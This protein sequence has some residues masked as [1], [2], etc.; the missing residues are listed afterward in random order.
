MATAT[1]VSG[2]GTT[3]TTVPHQRTALAVETAT[4][5]ATAGDT[6]TEAEGRRRRSLLRDRG[7]LTKIALAVGVTALAAVVSGGLAVAS[8]RGIAT[9][10]E[11]VAEIQSGL[12]ADIAIVHQEELK[13]RMLIAQVMAAATP[14]QREEWA[15]QIPETDAALD[16]AAA[17]IDPLLGGAGVGWESF[18]ENWAEWKSVRDTMLLPAAMDDDP[19]TFETKRRTIAQ[20]LVDKFVADL[21]KVEAGLTD[22]V[23]GVSEA[24][25]AEAAAA[26]MQYLLVLGVGLAIAA[27]VS[28]VVAHTIRRDLVDAQRSVAAMAAGDLTVEAPVRG[29][30]EVGRMS[31][32]LAVAQ[33]SL[34]RTLSEVDRT[35]DH[36]ASAAEELSA[37]GAQ[38]AAGAEETS[39][40][41]GV[42]AAA[43]EQ[44][45]RNVQAVAAGAEQMGASIRE[46]AQNAH[47]AARVAERATGVAAATNDQV[48]KLGV[49]S[50]EIGDVVK[51]ITSIAEQTNLLALNATI[52]AARAGEAGKGFAVVAGEVKELAQETARA[53][54]DI[55]RR[56]E[57]IQADTDGAVAAI[58]EISAIIAQINDFQMTIA[59]AVEEQTA[60]TNE[61]SRSVTEAAT[62]A[63]EIA[64]NITGVAGAAQTSSG[65]ATQMQSAVAELAR[66]AAELRGLIKV[67]AV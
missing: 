12:A 18:L 17:R 14:G 21:E 60:T 45:S 29:R 3:T 64:A 11:S 35:S 24:A 57:A 5:G 2:R 22:Y 38:V 37:A 54:E 36:V 34:R 47:E 48:A 28:Y 46:I 32:E 6:A 56:V 15:A 41:A 23:T 19:V 30:D 7:V 31:A 52:E 61:I 63:G 53:T 59:S 1:K 67:F 4:T 8:M 25:Q 39:A 62:G 65:V 20:P 44:V 51:V 40:Q 43:A 26:Q 33:K 66:M 42:V 58:G 49:S 27:A 9:D 13:A 10:L 50:R 16:A 55:A